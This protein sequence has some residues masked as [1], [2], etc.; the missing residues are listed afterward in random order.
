MSLR[1]RKCGVGGRSLPCGQWPISVREKDHAMLTCRSHYLSRVTFQV[2]LQ[3][4]SEVDPRQ[5]KLETS[6]LAQM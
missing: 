3:V 2:T 4:T 1:L 6:R 5:T